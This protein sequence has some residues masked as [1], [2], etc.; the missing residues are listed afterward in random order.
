[1]NHTHGQLLVKCYS[2]GLVKRGLVK[3]RSW[4]GIMSHMSE[5]IKTLYAA[6][7]YSHDVPHHCYYPHNVVLDPGSKGSKGGE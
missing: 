4:S 2:H 1:M 3:R 6:P 5:T 7:Y